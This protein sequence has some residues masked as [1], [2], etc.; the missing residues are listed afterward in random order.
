LNSKDYFSYQ[1]VY[2]KPE[3][4]EFSI[5]SLFA[6][7]SPSFFLEVLKPSY[8]FRQIRDDIAKFFKNEA[9]DWARS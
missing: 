1:F 9:L 7:Q 2:H 6:S 4:V 5:K 8:D 3:N